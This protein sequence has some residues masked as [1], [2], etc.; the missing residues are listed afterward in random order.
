M[1]KKKEDKKDN[2]ESFFKEVPEKGKS[3]MRTVTEGFSIN[4]PKLN[5]ENN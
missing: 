5:N 4:N 2:Y 1:S 3:D